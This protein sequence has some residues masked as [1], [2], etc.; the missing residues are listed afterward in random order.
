MVNKI[1]HLVAAAAVILLLAGCAAA[2]TA[3]GL[4]AE[5][6]P[7]ESVEVQTGEEAAAKELAETLSAAPTGAG[8]ICDINSMYTVE[9]HKQFPETAYLNA[10]TR[11]A[12]EPLGSMSDL[13]KVELGFEACRLIEAGTQR[14]DIHLVEDETVLVEGFTGNVVIIDAAIPSFCVEFANSELFG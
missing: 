6:D 3:N 10:L 5:E 8:E 9:C 14:E 4:I 13:D 12:G 11:N 7:A 1:T 2:P